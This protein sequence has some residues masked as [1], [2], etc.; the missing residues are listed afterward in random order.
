MAGRGRGRAGLAQ[1]RRDMQNLKRQVTILT[2]ALVNQ[3]IIP[4]D[5]FDEET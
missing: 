3:R 1:M 4:R 5:A 2:N